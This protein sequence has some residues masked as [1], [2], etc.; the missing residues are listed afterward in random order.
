MWLF[1]MQMSAV[2]EGIYSLWQYKSSSW[3]SQREYKALY[4]RWV[5]VVCVRMFR[6]AGMQAACDGHDMQ[7]RGRR[8]YSQYERWGATAAG[9]QDCCICGK[10]RSRATQA[11]R[12]EW[13]FAF[14]LYSAVIAAGGAKL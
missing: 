14:E 6:F 1:H 13:K 2:T 3:V 4:S 11:S 9:Q 12:I 8:F 7:R 10:Q 5:S